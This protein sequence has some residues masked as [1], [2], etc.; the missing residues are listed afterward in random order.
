M[1]GISSIEP[2][3]YTGP[4]S[5]EAIV[6][7]RGNGTFGDVLGKAAKDQDREA[8]RQAAAQL[9]SSTFIM[10]VLQS[11]HDSP[12]LE[13]PFA[14]SYAEK[15]FQPLLDQQVADR[16]TSA[17]Q[18]PLIDVIVDRLMGPAKTSET[19]DTAS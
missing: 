19:T 18:F 16:L 9:V 10:P 7:G 5:F 13:A 1:I 14:P 12:F 6:A 15:R 11:M 8:V 3:V 2:H 17:A 4:T